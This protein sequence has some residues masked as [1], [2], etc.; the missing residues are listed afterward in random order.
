MK[1]TD[2][3]RQVDSISQ[4]LR[5]LY[6]E[7]HFCPEANFKQLYELIGLSMQQRYGAVIE[8]SPCSTPGISSVV[9]EMAEEIAP[10]RILNV[11]MGGYPFIDIELTKRGFS[12]TGVEYSHSLTVLAREVSRH[13]GCEFHCLVA[14]GRRLPFGDGSFE[15]CLCSETVEHVPDD[16][17]VIREIH[18][19]LKPGGT[20]LFTV[21]CMVGLLGLTKRIMNYARNRT[22]ILHP[23]HLR[24]YTFFSA[25][26]LLNEYFRIERWYHIPFVTESFAKMPY[27]KL[28]SVL[29]SLP[30]LKY[31]SPS[32]A[33]IL[34]RRDLPLR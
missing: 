19:I 1:D 6:R 25:K 29:T 15:A 7:G 27:E 30:I 4:R 16:T 31:F 28:L 9:L 8:H 14:D 24:E 33:F 21:P 32:L 34:K 3:D 20:L 5:K 12:V 2:L 13:R 22:M 10:C 23:T 17:A 26:R 11:G 18:R